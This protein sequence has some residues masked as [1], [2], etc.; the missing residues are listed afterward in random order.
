MVNTLFTCGGMRQGIHHLYD[1]IDRPKA[2]TG[3]QASVKN[4]NLE[5][6]A[7]VYDEDFD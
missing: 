6:E 4:I 2:E 5:G 7:A 1:D 3:G